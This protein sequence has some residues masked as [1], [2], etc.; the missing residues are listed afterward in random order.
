MKLIHYFQN[1]PRSKIPD[2]NTSIIEFVILCITGLA[3]FSCLATD[4]VQ[5]SVGISKAS[6]RELKVKFNI[7]LILYKSLY[8]LIKNLFKFNLD[9]FHYK[10]NI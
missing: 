2:A 1:I 3:S 7:N 5:V 4:E 8:M 10:E 9:Y 6:L